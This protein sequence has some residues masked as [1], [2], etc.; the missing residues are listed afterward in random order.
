MGG[1]IYEK[2][3]NLVMTNSVVAQ[4][5]A[6]II[7]GGV[8]T[9]SCWG[10]VTNNTFDRNRAAYGGGNVYLGSSPS[11]MNVRNNLVTY[12]AMNGFQAASMSNVVFRF[13]NCFGNTSLDVVT[14]PAADST[15]TSRNPLYADTTSYDYHLLVNSG[16][17][18]TG[19][20]AGSADPDGSRADQGAFGGPAAFKAAP[21]YVRNLTAT[22]ANDTTI[23]LGWNG[24]LVGATSYA[25]YGSA[26][27]N[28]LPDAS[29][30]LGSVSV[31]GVA[32]LHHPV[33]G[34]RYYRVSG[35]SAAGYG[36]GY[37]NQA[38][39]CATGPD[40]IPPTVH[41]IY[42]N[43]KET[44]QVG[45]T[46]QIKW[47]ATDNR[48][49]DSVSIYCSK[50]AGAVYSV[51]THG[52]TADSTFKWVAT[53]PISDSCLVKVVAY[54]PGYNTGFDTSDSLFSI[55]ERT[56]VGDRGNG[57]GGGTP[58]YVTALEQNYPNPFNGVTTIHYSIGDRC[59]VE[60]RIYDPAGR[61]ISV[62]EHTDRTPGR[63]SVL[64][65][66]TDG[67]GRGVA[68]GVYFCR[69]KAGKFR[70]TRK[71]LYLR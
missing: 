54:D 49:V 22:A 12:G 31:P 20:P 63:Y 42:P 46:I 16:G 71:I 8:Y 69:I 55:K 64:W 68:S 27:N 15:N 43:G 1:G 53:A 34:C 48:Q 5:H 32:Y 61:L 36:G 26:V 50:N 35:V 24:L 41:V 60:L 66:G 25:M 2:G 57:N 30:Y 10:G 14:T 45:D 47:H 3:A 65:N 13:N 17:I 39:A 33:T 44:F 51:I 28:F 6:A 38:S 11:L 70:Q 56:G 4:N 23:S 18:D 29:V 21:D 58:V 40:L 62:L 59:E 37:S 19:D 67:A 52:C 9:D 7:G